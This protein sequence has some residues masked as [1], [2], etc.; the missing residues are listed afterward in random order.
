M[1]SGQMAIRFVRLDLGDGVRARQAREE[2]EC[3]DMQIPMQQISPHKADRVRPYDLITR[4]TA[5]H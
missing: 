4:D 1:P 5:G 2:K 3:R